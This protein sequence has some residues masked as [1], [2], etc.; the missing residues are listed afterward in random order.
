M[1]LSG[2]PSSGKTWIAHI[3]R[4]YRAHAQK[5][6]SNRPGWGKPLDHSGRKPWYCKNYHLVTHMTMNSM[7]KFTNIFVHFV[8]LGEA[9]GASRKRM[10]TQKAK[11]KKRTCS[12]PLLGCSSCRKGGSG[13]RKRP[14]TEITGVSGASIDAFVE[15]GDLIDVKDRKVYNTRFLYNSRAVPLK[16]DALLARKRHR[17]AILGS[18]TVRSH[19]FSRICEPSFHTISQAA[20]KCNT[21]LDA[22]QSVSNAYHNDLSHPTVYSKRFV[23]DIN[24]SNDLDAVES[25]FQ[26]TLA[27]SNTPGFESLIAGYES[28]DPVTQH[29]GP[30]FE[31]WEVVEAEPAGPGFESSWETDPIL[32]TDQ[33]ELEESSEQ[34]ICSEGDPCLTMPHNVGSGLDSR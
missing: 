13:G 27:K 2:I 22:G 7:G 16:V 28:H 5:H 14:V 29:S 30:G 19:V 34:N 6:V 25:S 33:E 24:M 10:S 18:N 12:C 32:P 20:L 9:S 8:W 15:S 23:G 31:P 26:N 3:D 21:S 11:Y 17:C 4:I 1:K